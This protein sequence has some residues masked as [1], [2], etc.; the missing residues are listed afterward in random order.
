MRA[1]CRTS[2]AADSAVTGPRSIF[3]SGRAD[4]AIGYRSSG[5]QDA[6][7]RAGSGDRPPAIS[8]RRTR[9]LGGDLRRWPPVSGR[10]SPQRNF[11]N[12]LLP[13]NAGAVP[14][15]L[16]PPRLRRLAACRCTTGSRS[17]DVDRLAAETAGPLSEQVA[18]S[19]L[20]RCRAHAT[21]CAGWCG[22]GNRRRPPPD[23]RAAVSL[24]SAK[25]KLPQ[26]LG[27]SRTSGWVHQSHLKSAF[28]VNRMLPSPGGSSQSARPRPVGRPSTPFAY[29]Q[30]RFTSL[31]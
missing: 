11:P 13:G 8:A 1:Q 22:G 31:P 15:P 18:R 25:P 16:L 27:V 30:V 17:P 7:L 3:P 10:R 23:S 5:Y 6:R 4:Y 28:I 12:S 29:P 2:A 24:R 14:W 9:R 21:R 26:C 20:S 19:A